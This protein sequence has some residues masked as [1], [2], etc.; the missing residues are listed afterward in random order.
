MRRGT[1]RLLSAIALSRSSEYRKPGR[2]A[3][4]NRLF[5]HVR[6]SGKR[7]W[8]F[9]YLAPSGRKRD[10]VLGE[11][12]RPGSHDRRVAGPISLDKARELAD[13]ART[14]LA[15]GIDPLDVRADERRRQAHAEAEQRAAKKAQRDLKRLTLANVARAY[16]KRAIVG[17]VRNDKHEAQWISSLENHLPD[18]IWHQTI[19]AIRPGDLLDA[20]TETQRETPETARRIRQRLDLIFAD[21]AM[22]ELCAAN[23]AA[24]IRKELGKRR[25][26]VRPGQFAAMPYADLPAFIGRLRG[27]VG[28]AARALEFAVLTAA[29]TTEVLGAK[30]NEFD[31]DA[32]VWTVPAERMK[33]GEPHA[34]YLSERALAILRGQKGV[35]ATYVFPSPVIEGQ[36]LSNMAMLTLLRRMGLG[37]KVTAHG[38]RATFS[39]WANETGA[40]RPDV[41]EA[42]L[43]HKEGDAVRRAY[44]RAQFIVDRRA[45]LAAWADYVEGHESK[46]GGKVVALPRAGK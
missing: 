33:A 6:D 46:H 31:M 26:K 25:G 41:V 17:H 3:D 1:S 8:L 29:R 2:Y 7:E 18:T 39:T 9:R 32:A 20:L 22:R 36:A 43:A 34:V 5:L 45:L 38:F 16:H 35:D 44:N 30:W 37:G 23:P 27:Q 42:V 15:E 40:A 4:G 10:M 24:A 21:A 12:D 28:P 13:K 14:L 11:Y 19:D